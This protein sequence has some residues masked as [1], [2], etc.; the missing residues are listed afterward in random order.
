M[1]V[2]THNKPQAK[3]TNND[4]R[5]TI[6][7]TIMLALSD[8]SSLSSSPPSDSSSSSSSSSGKVTVRSVAASPLKLSM[9]GT[10]KSESHQK[11][12]TSASSSAP[13]SK[14]TDPT[15]FSARL[16]KEKSTSKVIS[17]SSTSSNSNI[18]EVSSIFFFSRSS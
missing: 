4:K 10:W 16:S 6:E 15:K 2:V 18:V 11:V 5:D 3:M 17:P 13:I 12:R 9:A 14:R 8:S 7:L 1:V